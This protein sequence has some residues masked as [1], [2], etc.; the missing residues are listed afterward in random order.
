MTYV[1]NVLNDTDRA[2]SANLRPRDAA[3]IILI[4][5]SG[6]VP[7][8]LLGRR[9]NGHAFMPGKFV[10]PGGRV[11]PQDR[12]IALGG[13]LHPLIEARLRL[14]PPRPRRPMRGSR[15]PSERSSKRSAPAT[16]TASRRRTV[17]R[18]P[19]RCASPVV[20]PTSAW[21]SSR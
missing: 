21:R 11:E 20:S 8:V 13:R 9:H 2:S 6:D 4:D 18:S 1:A 14:A 5:R 7:K 12:R 17:T 3:T 10:F 19:S 15:R 16:G